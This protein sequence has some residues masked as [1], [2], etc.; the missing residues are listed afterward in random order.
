M[1]HLDTEHVDAA[2]RELNGEVVKTNPR[3]GRPYDHVTEVRNAAM[4][5]QKEADRIKS[6]LGSGDLTKKARGA[7]ETNLRQANQKLDELR[8]AGVF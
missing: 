5:L 8:K 7:L 6:M 4:G 1:Q 3:D 2:S